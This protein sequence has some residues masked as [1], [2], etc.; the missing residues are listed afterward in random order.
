MRRTLNVIGILVLG[1]GGMWPTS[2]EK[3]APT[4]DVWFGG[5]GDS[6]WVAQAE[7]VTEFFRPRAWGELRPHLTQAVDGHYIPLHSGLH[8]FGVNDKLLKEKNLPAPERLRALWPT[9]AS[10][11]S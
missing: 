7:G 4:F 5:S 6:Q 10:A 2:A 3:D 11:A 8:G 9:A 1:L